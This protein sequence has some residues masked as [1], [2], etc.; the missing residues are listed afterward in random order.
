[1]SICLW[2]KYFRR[3]QIYFLTQLQYI[4]KTE[5][6]RCLKVYSRLRGQRSWCLSSIRARPYF[7]NTESVLRLS[8]VHPLSKQTSF[9][10]VITN[11]LPSQLINYGLRP[12]RIEVFL[13]VHPQVWDQLKVIV[14]LGIPKQVR[15]VSYKRVCRTT[16]RGKRIYK[17]LMV[18]YSV[19]VV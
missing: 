9:L 18:Y 16:F 15:N 1:M 5:G 12:M 2:H 13:N 19:V 8:L 4:G 17:A 3:K 10:E 14:S 7:T 11:H 6:Y